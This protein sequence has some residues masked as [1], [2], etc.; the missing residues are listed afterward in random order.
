MEHLQLGF[1][2]YESGSIFGRQLNKS[3]VLEKKEDTHQIK[4]D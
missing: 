3:K 1:S 2:T 4:L